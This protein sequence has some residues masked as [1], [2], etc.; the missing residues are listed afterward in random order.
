M[1]V[2]SSM[3]D[4]A[5]STVEWVRAGLIGQVREVQVWTDR[6]VWPQGIKRPSDTPPVP[7][8]LDWDLWLGPAPQRP[9]HPAYHPFRFRGWYDFGTGALGD[10]GCHAFHVIVRALD[11]GPPVSVSA[12]VA[13]V[14]IPLESGDP[15]HWSG[16][17]RAEL[18]ESFPHA[19]IVTWNF[20]AHGSMP[21]V[22]MD[23]YDG[24]LKPPCPPELDGLGPAGILF[25]GDRGRILSG[26]S[27]GPKLVGGSADA[28]AKTLPRVTN[29][30][31]EWVDACKGAAPASCN[32]GFGSFLT[33]LTLLG[34]LAVRTRRSLKWDAAAGRTDS[35]S[36]N[37]FIDQ[38][39]RA[40]WAIS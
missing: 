28:P 32:F 10:M 12:S 35:D 25:I 1:S 15:E 3:S 37:A 17:K 24:G 5:C 29:H 36:A 34:N 8:T 21:P 26:F 38:P 7:S 40:G 33:E 31:R 13:D 27:G 20:P 2:Q 30:Y 22:Q 19:S 23:W 39:C 4:Y 6:P 9:Y 11:L 16:S 14:R 18:N